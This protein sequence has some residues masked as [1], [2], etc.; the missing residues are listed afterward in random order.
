[1]EERRTRDAGLVFVLDK[2]KDLPWKGVTM[3][4][5]Q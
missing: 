4:G 1:M 2:S 3:L 5:K